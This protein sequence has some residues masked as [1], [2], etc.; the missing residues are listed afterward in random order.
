MVVRQ[1]ITQ[2][3]YIV[4]GSASD[5]LSQ[6]GVRLSDNGFVD[7]VTDAVQVRASYL[8]SKIEGFV[9]VKPHDVNN[10]QCVLGVA[11]VGGFKR[12]RRSGKYPTR[13]IEA[14]LKRTL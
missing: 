10:G 5:W 9:T 14:A 1:R 13:V 8:T 7:I 11:V 2:H 12:R 4:S 6:L 3:Q